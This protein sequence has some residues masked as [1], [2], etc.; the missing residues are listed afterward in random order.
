M[1]AIIWCAHAGSTY[2]DRAICTEPCNAMHVRCCIC[3]V[4]IG[5]CPFEGPRQHDRLVQLVQAAT[6]GDEME[7]LG[8]VATIERAGRLGQ[9]LTFD[10][11]RRENRASC[12]QAPVQGWRRH[13]FSEVVGDQVAT[14]AASAPLIR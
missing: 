14:G 12:R 2:L 11:A 7:A 9:P 6:R 13:P 5:G 8:I 1:A 3:G 4:A 10:A